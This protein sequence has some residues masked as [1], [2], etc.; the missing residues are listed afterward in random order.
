VQ[1]VGVDGCGI[2]GTEMKKYTYSHYENQTEQGYKFNPKWRW[3]K[4]WVDKF[5]WKKTEYWQRFVSTFEAVDEKQAN[6]Y[7]NG[8]LKV[9]KKP[10]SMPQLELAEHTTAYIKT[11]SAEVTRTNIIPNSE[12]FGRY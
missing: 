7:V 11:E 2:G 8:F 5:V 3:W 6:E 1:G 12:K 9:Y 10:F 4:F